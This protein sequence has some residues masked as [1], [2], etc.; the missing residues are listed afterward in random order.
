MTEQLINATPYKKKYNLFILIG[1]EASIGH[2]VMAQISKLY[3]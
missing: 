3:T 1:L 2:V